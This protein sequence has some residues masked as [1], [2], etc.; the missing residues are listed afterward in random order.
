MNLYWIMTIAGPILLGAVL[1]WAMTHNRTSKAQKRRTEEAT[2]QLY[3]EQN[4]TDLE[5]QR[6]A[7]NSP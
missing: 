7:D 3:Q 6:A 1:L 2:R 4:E 5:T